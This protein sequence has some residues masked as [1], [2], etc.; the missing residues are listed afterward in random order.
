MALSDFL[1]SLRNRG[2][3]LFP[4]GWWNE[5]SSWTISTHPFAKAVY[6]SIIDKITNP[7]RGTMWTLQQGESG[8]YSKFEYFFKTNSAVFVNKLLADGAAYLGWGELGLLTFTDS[9]H[10]EYGIKTTDYVCRGQSTEKIIM[11]LLDYLDDI[12]NASQTSIKRLGRL[13]LMTPESDVYGPKMTKAELEDEE[14]KFEKNY[15]FLEDQKIVKILN[16]PYKIQDINVS[17]S[18]LNL[19]SRQQMAVKIVCD[20][21]GVPYE[22]VA[23]SIV[24]NPNQT[25]VYQKEAMI[26]LYQ[27]VHYYDDLFKQL[28]H[29]MGLVVEWDTPDAPQDY[30]SDA[31]ELNTK[32]IAN[33]TTA[34]NAGYIT[35]EEAI[36]TY[37]KKITNYDLDLKA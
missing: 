10:S 14:K 1:H 21:L 37:R 35:H 19:D 8:K 3:R 17:G 23:A 20:K 16:Y 22:L 33:I 5:G 36:E 11:P 28:A 6:T 30:S 12:I 13:V 25:G 9:A 26:R 31:E 32:I 15:G 7:L 4:L 29:Q 2:A 27:T 24:G 18:G 34:E